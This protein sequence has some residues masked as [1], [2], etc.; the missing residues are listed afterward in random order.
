[1]S[2]DFVLGLDHDIARDFA[3]CDEEVCLRQ[4]VLV[5]M[6]TQFG[7]WPLDTGFGMRWLETVLVADPDLPTVCAAVRETL[8]R[9]DGIE[10]VDASGLYFDGGELRGVVRANQIEV[11]L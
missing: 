2:V 3:L 1:V 7:Q 5:A 9:L 4:R 6:R 10:T 11:A 8:L